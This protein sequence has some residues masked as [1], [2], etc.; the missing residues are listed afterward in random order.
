MD[1]ARISAVQRAAFGRIAEASLVERLRSDGLIITSI[2]ADLGPRI[3]GS[4][5]FS[6][7]LIFTVP[8]TMHAV[9]LGPVAVHPNY[10]GR[11]VGTEII[12]AGLDKCRE[13][14]Y[15]AAI[16]LG[17]PGY[18]ERF[19]FSAEASAGLC[20]RYAGPDWMALELIPGALESVR[21]EVKYPPP[22]AMLDSA[23]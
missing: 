14:G 16:V 22:F 17:D 3:I 9:A 15:P 10:Q 12:R 6:K 4:V 1:E 5:I 19:G 7:L 8:E 11:G 21:G 13:L 2:V 23:G 18:Y 20:S